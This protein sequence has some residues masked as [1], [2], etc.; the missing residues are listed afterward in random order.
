MPISK[1]YPIEELLNVANAYAQKSGKLI[2]FE[3]VLIDKYNSSLQDAKRLIQL[4]HR[5]P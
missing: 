5:I 4:K 1:K 3:Y 2:T